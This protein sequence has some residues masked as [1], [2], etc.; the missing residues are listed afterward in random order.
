VNGVTGHEPVLTSPGG[1]VLR[2]NLRWRVFDSAALSI[3]L[4]HE[5]AAMTLDVHAGLFETEPGGQLG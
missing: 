2:N 3:G 5:P 1:R 4:G